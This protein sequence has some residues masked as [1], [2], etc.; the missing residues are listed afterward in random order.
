M[1]NILFGKCCSICYFHFVCF[2]FVYILKNLNKLVI[3]CCIDLT[4]YE[5]K[6]KQSHAVML[7]SKINASNFPCSTVM[8]Q[9]K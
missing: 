1:K 8:R 6:P 3:R 5:G 7:F 9:R 2:Y 4:N